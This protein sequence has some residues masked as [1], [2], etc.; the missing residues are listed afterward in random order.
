[1]NFRPVW[2]CLL[3]WMVISGLQAQNTADK[4]LTISVGPS[5]LARQDLIFSPFIH[6]GISPLNTRI[7][8]QKDKKRFQYAGLSYS[9]FSTG[10]ETPYDYIYDDEVATAFPHS[11]TFI[12]L[13][14]GQGKYWNENK[15][16]LI[17]GEIN[18]D[19]QAL[20]YQYGRSGFFGYCS[21]IGLH[22]WLKRVI[23][24]TEKNQ[25]TAR[26][27]LPLVSWLARSPYL[28]NDDTFIENTY[29]HQGLKTFFAFLADG[30][31]ATWGELHRTDI[32]I[33]FHHR[34]SEKLT[35]GLGYHLGFLHAAKPVDLFSYQHD[36]RLNLSLSL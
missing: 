29:S 9:A 20:N 36:L 16:T 3:I 32:D 30:H 6:Q 7:S 34:V 10:L 11:L 31:I 25:I 4:Q 2:I 18:L 33:D 28:I 21:T 26:I 8:Y 24:R 27:E 23:V 22:A 14:Y 1:M 19:V 17:G 5:L 12:S 35:L 13:E 15:R